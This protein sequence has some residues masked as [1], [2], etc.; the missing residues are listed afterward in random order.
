[1]FGVLGVDGEALSYVKLW[2]T[3]PRLEEDAELGGGE[4]RDPEEKV[5]FVI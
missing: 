1:M 4:L 3:N 2:L 5:S